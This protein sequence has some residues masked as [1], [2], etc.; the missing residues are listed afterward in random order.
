MPTR[1]IYQVDAFTSRPF[2]GN[3]AGVLP[4]AEGLDE[5]IM[6]K[7]A[8][9]MALSETAFIFPPERGGDF[10]VRF[11]TPQA[12]VKLCG[13]ATV[14]AFHLLAEL[15]II[16]RPCRVVQETAAGLLPVEVSAGGTVMMDQV[17]PQYRP[18]RQLAELSSILGSPAVSGEPAIVSTGLYDLIVPIKDRAALWDMRPDFPRLAKL[19]TQLGVTSV[20]AFTR[21]TLDPSHTAHCRD[22]APAV[23]IPEEA[24][25]GTASGATAAYLVQHGLL[26]A[27]SQLHLTFEQGHILGRPSLI[28]AVIDMDMR[29]QAIHRVR[30]GGKA[31]TVMAGTL[32]F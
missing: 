26:P 3:P 9:E 22:F 19:C 10:Q 16:P 1:R 13:H 23:G 11:F 25:T 28:Q 21:D 4:E 15:G 30:V 31:V 8:R 7:I 27:S 32:R 12:E 17:L 5:A 29:D 24:A 20:H 2:G 18:F 14:A 6:Q